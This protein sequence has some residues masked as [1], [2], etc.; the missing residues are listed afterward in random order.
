ML[1]LIVT[2]GH[3]QTYYC[4]QFMKQCEFKNIV[5]PCNLMSYY[6]SLLGRCQMIPAAM[7]FVHHL[8]FDGK[9]GY[10]NGKQTT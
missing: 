2:L 9:V 10:Q 3:F 8:N 1:G 7:T 6:F 4:G 5:T